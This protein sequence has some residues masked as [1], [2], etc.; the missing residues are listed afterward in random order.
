MA[1]L[2]DIVATLKTGLAG[3]RATGAIEINDPPLRSTTLVVV[4]TNVAYSKTQ[5]TKVAMMAN[6]GGAW[7]IRPYHTT[8]DGDQLFAA[9][10]GRLDQRRT[11][12]GDGRAGGG[13]RGRGDRARR[14]VDGPRRIEA[15]GLD[16]DGRARHHRGDDQENQEHR[17]PFHHGQISATAQTSTFDARSGDS[18]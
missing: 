15:R 4:A 14:R 17:D 1:R 7:A 16:G 18:E 3:H 9:S 5:L 11:A 13:S 2:A 12:L 10:T 8:G 6:A